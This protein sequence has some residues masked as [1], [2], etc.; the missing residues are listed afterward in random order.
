MIE[1]CL[2]LAVHGSGVSAVHLSVYLFYYHFI[3]CNFISPKCLENKLSVL[4]NLS[5]GLVHI[6]FSISVLAFWSLTAVRI[7]LNICITT[8]NVSLDFVP[9]LTLLPTI[10]SNRLSR[11]CA[12]VN[13][14]WN[15]VSTCVVDTSTE[16]FW[17]GD[18]I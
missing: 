17:N 2:L 12:K 5:L 16:R 7:L 14:A 13:F 18:H 10:L 15:I 9:I 6:I 3:H 1:Q 11:V 4:P 8:Y